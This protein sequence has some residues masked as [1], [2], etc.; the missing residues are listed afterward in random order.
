MAQAKK[1]RRSKELKFKAALEAFGGDKTIVQ[2]AEKYG[3]HPN[4]VSEWKKQLLE[5]GADIFAGASEKKGKAS[6]SK[7]ELLIKTIGKQQV[8]IDWLKKKLGVSD[9][10]LDNL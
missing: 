9:F 6:Q 10:E 2:I 5:K 4:Q 3:V 1:G 7:D 8:H